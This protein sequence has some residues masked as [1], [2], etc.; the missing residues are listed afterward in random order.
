MTAEE[1]APRTLDGYRDELERHVLPIL[2]DRPV[3]TIGPDDLVWWRRQMQQR[4]LS[5]WS[6]RHAW[7]PLRLVLAFAVRHYGLPANPAG[8]L[9]SHERPKTGDDRR[10]FLDREEIAA[11]LGAASRPLPERRDWS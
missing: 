8:A 5:P 11:L 6:I 9:L 3:L 2:G 7:T 4:R 10:R 1:L